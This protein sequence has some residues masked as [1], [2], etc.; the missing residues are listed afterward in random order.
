MRL[1][2]NNKCTPLLI[3]TT[4]ALPWPPNSTVSDV[5]ASWLG[6]AAAVAGVLSSSAH[7]V[8]CGMLCKK[9]K[10]DSAT[11]VRDTA[12]LQTVALSIIGPCMDKA[13]MKTYPWQWKHAHD[14]PGQCH[15]I[16]L[17][18]CALAAIVNI[19]LVSCIKIYSATGEWVISVHTDLCCLPDSTKGSQV[20][21]HTKTVVIL[22]V[23]WILHEASPNIVIWRQYLGSVIAFSGLIAYNCD[24]CALAA[25]YRVTEIDIVGKKENNDDE[26]RVSVVVTSKNLQDT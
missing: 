6:L 4:A 16:I 14:T 17:L 1:P 18:S 8:A 19:S 23:S 2:K 13:L 5:S 7:N 22:A 20:L 12:P 9:Y 25:G 26:I 21:G 11:L 3:L 24:S 15:S 10:F